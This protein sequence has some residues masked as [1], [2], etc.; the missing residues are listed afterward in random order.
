MDSCLDLAH[1]T[2]CSALDTQSDFMMYMLISPI[3]VLRYGTYMD[4]AAPLFSWSFLQQ[5]V[6]PTL[7]EAQTGTK[8]IWSMHPV[9]AVAIWLWREGSIAVIW[10]S[11]HKPAVCARLACWPWRL[12][13]LCLS[14]ITGR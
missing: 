9:Y 6:L 1:L 7:V 5:I 12:N 2:W 8:A 3:A 13:F 11:T 14:S 10:M 4:T